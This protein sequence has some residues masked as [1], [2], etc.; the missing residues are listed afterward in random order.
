MQEKRLCACNIRKRSSGVP[1]AVFWILLALIHVFESIS[2]KK[3]KLDTSRAT[4]VTS[5]KMVKH[6]K[7]LSS[8]VACAFIKIVDIKGKITNFKLL[9]IYAINIWKKFESK[10]I[11]SMRLSVVESVCKRCLHVHVVNS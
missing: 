1:R 4:M 11:R 10:I 7:T 2:K 3:F 9:T 5:V 8:T 6:H